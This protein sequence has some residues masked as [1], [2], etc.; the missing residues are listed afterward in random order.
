LQCKKNIH[1]QLEIAFQKHRHARASNVKALSHTRGRT[2]LLSS[3]NG[4]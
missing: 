3:Q 4:K 2:L 1:E